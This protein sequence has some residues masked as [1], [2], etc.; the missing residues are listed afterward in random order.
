M[1]SGGQRSAIWSDLFSYVNVEIKLPTSALG[2]TWT[3]LY[4]KMRLLRE[5]H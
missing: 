3:M 2:G 1:G 5:K 4:C